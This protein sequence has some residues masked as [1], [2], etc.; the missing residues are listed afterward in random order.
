MST[1]DI[2]VPGSV[3]Y[4]TLDPHASGMQAELGLPEPRQ[5]KRGRGQSFRYDAVPIDVALELAE[6]IGGRASMLLGQSVNDS[7]DPDEKAE[8][9]C[10]RSAIKTAERIR[11]HAKA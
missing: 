8:R 5:I 11:K 2:D 1:I 6:Y 10:Y 3:W 4:D 9:D 7:H